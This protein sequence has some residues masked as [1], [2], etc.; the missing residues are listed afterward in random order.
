MRRA[1]FVVF[2]GVLGLLL[3]V[4]LSLAV[5]AIAGGHLSE[6]VPLRIQNDVRTSGSPGASA[7]ED[8]QTAKHEAASATETPSP[9]SSQGTVTPM[10]SQ[11]PNEDSAG[12]NSGEGASG[13]DD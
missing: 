2:A 9:M 3:G 13:T 7:P 10:P 11:N 1:A 12:S 5:D 4:G 6:P 8:H